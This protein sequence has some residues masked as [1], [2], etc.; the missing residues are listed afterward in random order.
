M[1]FLLGKRFYRATGSG[2]AVAAKTE[3]IATLEGI[4]IFDGPEERVFV[5][6]GECDGRIVLDLC[7]AQ[8]RVVVIDEHGWEVCSESPIRFPSAPGH[9]LVAGAGKGRI[10]RRPA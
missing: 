9:A 8:W 10:T 3:A 1:T 2:V 7:D 5:R 4:A 6:I